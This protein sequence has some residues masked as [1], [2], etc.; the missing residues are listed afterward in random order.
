[1]SD[2]SQNRDW[3]TA[4]VRSAIADVNGQEVAD[5]TSEEVLELTANYLNLN[6]YPVDGSLDASQNAMFVSDVIIVTLNQNRH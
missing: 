6:D 3:T 5:E 1:M 4:D 2:A